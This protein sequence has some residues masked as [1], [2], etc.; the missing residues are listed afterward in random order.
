MILYMSRTHIS[1]RNWLARPLL[2]N[3]GFEANPTLENILQHTYQTQCRCGTQFLEYPQ[4][5][6][7]LKEK[8]THWALPIY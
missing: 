7:I 1:K 6:P 5:N 3:L 2:R 4:P 8:H